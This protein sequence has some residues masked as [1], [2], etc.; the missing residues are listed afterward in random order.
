MK[1]SELLRELHSLKG[2]TLITFH[3][4][5]DVEAVSSAIALSKFLKN[6][7]AVVKSPDKTNSASRHLLQNLALPPLAILK[8][9]EL[10]A[11]DNMVLVDVANKEM[12]GSFG[13]EIKQFKGKIIA[14]DHHEHGGLLK[15]CHVFEF[16]Q[17]TS[18]CEIVHDLYRISGRKID[19][20]TATLLLA[21]IIA[22]TARFKTANRETFHAASQLLIASERKYEEVLSLSITNPDNSEVKAVQASL[23]NAKLVETKSGLIGVTQSNAFESKCALTLVEI[24]CV[25]GICYNKKLGKIAM[26]KNG[27]DL[28]SKQINV[29]KLMKTTGKEMHGSGGGHESVGGA[30]GKSEMV[31]KSVEKL[32]YRIKHLLG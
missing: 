24:G 17:R 6:V 30:L 7:N 14:I 31:E 21:G 20:K 29:G 22:D 32:V 23:T 2:A 25:A 1:Y 4:L 28:R 3:S 10:K 11:F 15:N 8:S 16:P 13:D 26:V 18:C 27:E 19:S 5:G 12:L 9:S